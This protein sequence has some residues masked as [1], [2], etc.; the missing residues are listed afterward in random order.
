MLKPAPRLRPLCFSDGFAASNGTGLSDWL[1]CAE[2]ASGDGVRPSNAA[3][4]T[5]PRFMTM[6]LLTS[7]AS[8]PDHGA[9]FFFTD[10]PSLVSGSPPAERD[11]NAQ[12][13]SQKVSHPGRDSRHRHVKHTNRHYH[14]ADQKGLPR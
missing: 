14:T 6:G 1:R 9:F 7:N 8:S 12:H 13:T 11:V 10:A 3:S 5:I 2:V 4:F